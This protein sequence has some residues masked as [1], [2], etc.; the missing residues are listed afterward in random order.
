V[1]DSWDKIWRDKGGRGKVVIWQTPNA[2]LIAWAVLTVLSL[3]FRG[4]T[5]DYISW[6]AHASLIIWSLWEL[7]KGA[8]Y[9]RR[10]LGL[11]VLIF[12]IMS[13]LQNL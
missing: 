10:I 2:F 8:N 5:S 6:A 9:F 12:A 13:L 1:A 4:R 3:L 7:F 11:V